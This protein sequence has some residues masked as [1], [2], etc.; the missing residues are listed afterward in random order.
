M[1]LLLASFKHETNTFSPVP[2]PAERFF[3]YRPVMLTGEAAMAAHR[4]TGSALGGFLTV[5][6]QAG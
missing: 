4:G 5:A 6:E 2:T 3:G 1:K